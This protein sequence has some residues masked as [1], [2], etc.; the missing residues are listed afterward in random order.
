MSV[1]HAESETIVREP[2]EHATTVMLR[3]APGEPSRLMAAGPRTR[4]LYYAG[5]P[6]PSCL[7]VRL[8]PGRAASLLGRSVR[9]LVDQAVP[10]EG[11]GVD[12][13]D[14]PVAF[15]AA[16]VDRAS[17]DLHPHAEL[18]GEAA[19]LVP[20]IGVRRSSERLH[21]SERRLR[22]LFTELVGIPPKRFARIDRVRAVLEHGAPG[23]W[24]ELA[25]AV[26][27]ADHSHLTAEFRALM[28]MPPTTFFTG[29]VLPNG[30]CGKSFETSTAYS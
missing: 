19:E 2:P 13:A 4:P 25:L 21:L 7:R 30:R 9:G 15:A 8:R 28:G 27:Y 22:E 3:T 5:G 29:T 17:D 12:L 16:L 14:D 6:G 18:I 11:W 23:R 24:S 1:S 26:G 20:S 10:L